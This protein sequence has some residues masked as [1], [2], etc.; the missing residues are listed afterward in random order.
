[1]KKTPKEL[2]YYFPAEWEDHK[3]TWLSFPHNTETWPQHKL[4]RIYPVFYELIKLLSWEE[5][6]HVN[7]QN[8]SMQEQILDELAKIA[9]NIPQIFFHLHPTNDAWCRDYGPAF[10]I[11]P[12]LVEKKVI[13][14][15]EFNAWGQKY[16]L[17]ESDNRIPELIAKKLSL[18]I[19]KPQ[20]VME[21]G[22]L[23]F[24]GKGSV[25][26][27][28]GCL[29]NKNRN[30]HLT[31]KQIEW[32]LYDYYGVEQVLWL[33]NGLVGDDTDGHIDNLARFVSEDTIITMI[34]K[35]KRSENYH[36]L[37]DNLS[38]LKKM[39]LINGKQLNVIEVPMPSAIVEDGVILPASYANFYIANN[40][41]IV[42]VYQQKQ[43]QE[44]IEILEKC[45][46]ERKVI[47]LDSSDIIWGLG[48]FHCLTQQEPAL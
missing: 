19:Y 28:K 42:P 27:T 33:E 48:S 35:N 21:G 6:V 22:S 38:Q 32:A 18:P 39:R 9:A 47:G 1:M 3:A 12:Y 41:V 40:L 24:N 7:V 44:A 2:G 26:T 29:L 34:D 43:D 4:E 16:P 31:I 15:W 14:D 13:V 46:P 20:I 37:Q 5:E 36:I 23:D 30:L 25:L 8:T 11:N 45:F 10:L 17:Y